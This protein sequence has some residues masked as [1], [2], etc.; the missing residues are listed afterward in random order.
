VSLPILV[1]G[2]FVSLLL[3]RMKQ[4]KFLRA[5]LENGAQLLAE[6]CSRKSDPALPTTDIEGCCAHTVSDLYL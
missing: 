5:F 2:V 3:N 6:I 1:R 4:A